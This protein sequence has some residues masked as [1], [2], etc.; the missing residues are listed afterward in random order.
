MT[1]S[2][3]DP[4]GHVCLINNRVI[5]VVDHNGL[6]KLQTFLSSA[7]SAQFL[8][9][10]NLV[11]TH[12]LDQCAT[13]EILQH[14]EPRRIYE[15]L[16]G[17]TLVEHDRVWF[18]TFPYEWPAEMLHAAAA[19][20]LEFAE[21]LLDDGLGLKDASPYNV[22]FHGPRPVFVDL[23]SFE[24]RDPH[25][26]TWLPFAQF[27]RTFLL[28]L[29]VNKRFGFPL[30]DL[31]ATHRDGLEPEEVLHLLSP[32][33]KLLPPFLTLVSIPAWLSGKGTESA[34]IYQKQRLSDPAKARFIL[35]RLLNSMQCKLA[36]SA[37]RADCSSVWSNYM[38]QNQYSLDYFPL[39]QRFVGNVFRD[40]PPTRVLDVGCNTGYFSMIAAR[41]GASVV[42]IDYDAVVVG[43]V[44]RQAH[45]EKLD[46]LPLVINIAHPTPAIGWRN[47]ECASFLERARAQFDTVLML[48]V[49]HHLLV[50]ERI[51]LAE[52]M[53][54][55]AELT[56]STLVIEFV[57]PDDPMFRRITRGNDHLY[58]NVTKEF[59]EEVCGRFF[60][61]VRCER[62]D[63]TNR[64]LYLMKKKEAV[65][66]C[67]ETQQ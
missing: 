9:S 32:V 40:Q 13:D 48:G 4:D 3:R 50:T 56:T 6:S 18:P 38:D 19:L 63:Q 5:R 23:L 39:K 1:T 46:I 22:L 44:W 24:S 66:E 25:D 60:D 49:I 67:F 31:L 21:Q 7:A 58:T 10:Q 59:F 55:A 52:I 20:T 28:P 33:Q 45:A 27:V 53:G 2:L 12:F 14:D 17:A 62:L 64:W 43:K 35:R 54:L 65:I 8:E 41:A 34:K 29:L 30:G 61:V 57:A 11:N 36:A 26:P 16:Q 47:S 42:A 51:P 37:P 15:Q